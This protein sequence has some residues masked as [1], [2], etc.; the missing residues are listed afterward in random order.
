MLRLFDADNGTISVDGVNLKEYKLSSWLGR[1]GFVSQDTFILH[2]TVRNNITFGSDG[3]SQEDIIK[4]AKS[5]NVHDFINELL[6]GYDTIV[7]ERGMKLSGGQ[8]QRIAI[9]RAIIRKPDIL[10]FDEA[11]SSLDNI[12]QTLVQEAISR[13]SENRTMLIITHRLSAI[14]GATK[15]IVIENGRVMEEGTHKE[16]MQKKGAYWSLYK[17]QEKM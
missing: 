17:S 8:K 12:S 16:L 1:I 6:Q 9:A 3:Y 7:G 11:T 10:I 13:I 5:A 4:V 14:I 2:D 15:I